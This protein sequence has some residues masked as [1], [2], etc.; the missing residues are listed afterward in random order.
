[1]LHYYIVP[2]CVGYICDSR[3]LY[4]QILEKSI[5]HQRLVQNNS[6]ALC[7]ILLT[8][9]ADTWHRMARSFVIYYD[10]GINIRQ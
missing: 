6:L 7:F 1:M 3:Q 2:R 5:I 8:L 10:V 9:V 4:R